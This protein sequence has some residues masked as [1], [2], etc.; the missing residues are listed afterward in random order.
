[1]STQDAFRLTPNLGP[2]TLSGCASYSYHFCRRKPMQRRSDAVVNRER[3]PWC[4]QQVLSG[5]DDCANGL[6]LR[7]R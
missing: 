7:A 3:A 1:M 6:R 4:R 2:K 5:E